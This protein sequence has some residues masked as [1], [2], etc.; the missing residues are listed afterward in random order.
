MNRFVFIIFRF[1]VA[2]FRI[3]PFFILYGISDMA[4]LVIFYL[5]GYRKKVVYE[6]LRTSFPEK[7]QKEIL[8][9]RR[10]FY[11]HLCDIIIE[12][13]KGFSLNEKQLLQRYRVENP[14]I[15]S[16]FFNQNK[17]I[18][19]LASHYNNWEY[20]IL[21]LGSAF[22]HQAVSIYM[23]LSNP[24]MEKYGTR[25]RSRYGMKMLAVQDTRDYFSQQH[26]KPLAVI[27]AADQ[28][29][30][31]V[32]KLI[33]TNFLGKET[34]CLHGPEAYAK[35]M[36]APIVYFAVKKLKRGF[37]SLTLEMLNE[38]PT[39]TAY[40]EITA[41]YMRRLEKDIVVRPEY[42]LWSH[43]RWKHRKEDISEITQNL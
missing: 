39:E 37:Y 21:A 2:W 22:Q 24:Y 36:N 38:N 35:K 6:N 8:Q 34:A 19:C 13:I 31:N 7:T 14:E 16:L 43:R 20:G 30:S 42:W 25:V 32:D 28:S 12:T 18:I 27:L 9:I 10:R 15:T 4:Y 3:T 41:Q 40:G 1:L 33:W 26:E 5:V 23:K 29:P 11:R 17:N